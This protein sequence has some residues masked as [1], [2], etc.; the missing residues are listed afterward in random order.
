MENGDNPAAH[1][2]NTGPEIFAQCEGK[3]DTFIHGIGT[4]G[5]IQGVGTYLKQQKADV[6]VGVKPAAARRRSPAARRR[7]MCPL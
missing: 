7:A 2:A 1:V 3:I 4:G 5:C 6:K